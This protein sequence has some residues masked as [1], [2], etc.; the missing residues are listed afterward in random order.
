MAEVQWVVNGYV[1]A[2]AG[3]LLL[4]GRCADIFGRRR[5][6]VLGLSTLTLATLLAGLSPGGVVLVLARVAQGLGAAMALPVA[7]ALIPV[8]FADPPRRDRAYATAALLSSLAWV[9]G[10]LSGGLLTDLVGWRFVFLATAPFSV[11]AL[12]LAVRV[13]PES[14]DDLAGRR[15]DVG[16]ALLITAALTSIVY[17]VTRAEHAGP[18]SVSVLGPLGLGVA[19]LGAFV[20]VEGRFAQP[21]VPLRMFRV[22]E[23]WGASLGVGA[24]TAAYG[25]MVFIGTLYL[26]EVMGY[27]P[28]ATGLIFLSLAAGALAGPWLARGLSHTGARPLGVASLLVCAGALAVLAWLAGPGGSHLALILV[29]MLAFGVAQYAAWLAVVGQATARVEAGL[30][31]V[32]SGVFKTSTHIGA[33]VAFAASS[34]IIEWVGASGTDE[35]APYTAAYLTIAALTTLGAV[36]VALLINATREP[37]APV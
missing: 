15:I 1:L 23:L 25:G 18:T 6:L 33:A 35:A 17:G 31:G 20:V 24:N 26:Q 13:L 19:L 27:S 2:L 7:M 28:T 21:L 16:G 36:A 9:V 32:A 10:A 8:L 11:L 14:R 34:T 22:R 5:V 29:T 12:I 4:G 3:A 30:Y 37:R